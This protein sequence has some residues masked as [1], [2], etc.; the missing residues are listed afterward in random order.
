MFS[1]IYWKAINAQV[2]I[3]IGRTL[4]MG[5]IYGKN[6]NANN[7]IIEVVLTF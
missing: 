5:Q 1:E 4:L 7:Q 6:A 2:V 3:R